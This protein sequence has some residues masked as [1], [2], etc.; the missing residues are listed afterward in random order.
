MSPPRQRRRKS[1]SPTHAPPSSSKLDLPRILDVDPVRRRERERQLAL[2]LAESTIEEGP[3]TK[4]K[5]EFD[6][7]AEYAKLVSTKSGGGYMTPALMR[8]LQAAASEDK[9]SPEFQRLSWD[10]LRKSLTGIVNR[11]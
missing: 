8:A 3:A 6:T 10:A 1:P 11:V 7:K 9:S 5:P 4:E 2:K